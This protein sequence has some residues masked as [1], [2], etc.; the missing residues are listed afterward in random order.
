M[1][2]TSYPGMFVPR[3]LGIIPVMRGTYTGVS[4]RIIGFRIIPVMR[5]T[6]F[7]YP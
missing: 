4:Y 3:Y 5:G 2:G 6:F 7:D 1:R